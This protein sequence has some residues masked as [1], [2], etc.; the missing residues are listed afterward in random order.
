MPGDLRES[1]KT[2]AKKERSLTLRAAFGLIPD[3]A[4]ELAMAA[5]KDVERGIA[6]NAVAC[7]KIRVASDPGLDPGEEAPR[8]G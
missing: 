1:K 5:K 6:G 8:E 7:E 3:F 4:F 2:A